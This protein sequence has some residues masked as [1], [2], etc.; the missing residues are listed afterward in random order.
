MPEIWFSGLFQKSRTT[1]LFAMQILA[2]SAQSA[3]FVKVIT[4]SCTF[5][6]MQCEFCETDVC[7]DIAFWKCFVRTLDRMVKRRCGI[8]YMVTWLAHGVDSLMS[9]C[10]WLS[11]YDRNGSVYV[12]VVTS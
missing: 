3:V 6:L 9:C 4:E 11:A 5:M 7:F 10:S 8:W 12:V 1:K 2:Q